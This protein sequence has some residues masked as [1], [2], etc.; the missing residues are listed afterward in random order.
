MC[1][2]LLC[3]FS[4]KSG[5]PC[6]EFTTTW[7]TCWKRS[8]EWDA[9]LKSLASFTPRSALSFTTRMFLI[10]SLACMKLVS[11]IHSLDG[12]FKNDEFIFR[13]LKK[14]FRNP[15]QCTMIG[16]AM[17]PLGYLAIPSRACLINGKKGK[18]APDARFL[19]FWTAQLFSKLK[20][21]YILL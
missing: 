12:L 5:M 4:R 3:L 2:G 16:P 6:L 1:L 19:T 17:V 7:S 18:A 15:V 14:N 10:F 9:L 13:H 8:S 20:C 21:N 11:S